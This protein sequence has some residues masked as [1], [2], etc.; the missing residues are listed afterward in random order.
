MRRFI[1]G[2]GL[3]I[4]C[5]AIARAQ[6]VDTTEHVVGPEVRL[7]SV[8]LRDQG[9]AQSRDPAFGMKVR[10]RPSDAAQVASDTNWIESK[11]ARLAPDTV[12]VA[13]CSHCR[14][15]KRALTP[16]SLYSFQRHTGVGS[17]G[18]NAKIGALAGALAGIGAVGYSLSQCRP[19]DDLCG[20]QILATPFAAAGG[21]I[22][23]AIVG[24]VILPGRWDPWSPNR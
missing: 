8:A 14:D 9:T 7:R 5:V 19:N 13:V 18:G 23:G 17:R 20:I 4:G 12:F 16:V 22:V 3:L 1:V 21:A 15:P 10:Y 6:T 24:A 11:V 2:V